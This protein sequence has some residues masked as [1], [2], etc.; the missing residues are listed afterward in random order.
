M[1]ALSRSEIDEQMRGFPP[2]R[3]RYPVVAPVRVR[4]GAQ[5]FQFSA[6]DFSA[7]G[8]KLAVPPGVDRSA[9]KE[10]AFVLLNAAFLGIPKLGTIIWLK[11]DRFGVRFHE[12]L[13]VTELDRV[14]A[15]A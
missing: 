15:R 5:L 6:V 3:P 11:K 8:A 4:A 14:R 1:T 10:G 9:L 7:G 13:S 2:R 12:P